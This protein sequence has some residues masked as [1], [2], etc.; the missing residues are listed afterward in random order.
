MQSI[1]LRREPA[2]TRRRT[3]AV[4]LT[5]RPDGA[6]YAFVVE[7]TSVTPRRERTVQWLGRSPSP[8]RIQRAAKQWG[9]SLPGEN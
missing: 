3:R 8:E 5:V 4:R 1:H 2:P 7:I 9:A 6:I